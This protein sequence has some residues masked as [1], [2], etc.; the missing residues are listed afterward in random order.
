[1]NKGSTTRPAECNYCKG[2]FEYNISEAHYYLGCEKRWVWC[3]LCGSIT[4]VYEEEHPKS[5]IEP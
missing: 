4:T 1:M 2:K 3:P 5:V